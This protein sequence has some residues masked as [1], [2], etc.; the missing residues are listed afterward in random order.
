[1]K[2]TKGPWIVVAISTDLSMN[3]I[4]YCQVNGP[5]GIVCTTEE[6]TFEETKANACLIAAAPEML[7]ELEQLREALND[8]V[9]STGSKTMDEE[10]LYHI[11]KII[12]KAKGE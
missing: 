3:G 9:L 10:M 6:S 5:K 1:M 2:H 12:K 11:Q 7:E 4:G 8:T